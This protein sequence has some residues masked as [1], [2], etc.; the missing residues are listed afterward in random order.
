MLRGR[1][2]GSV[3]TRILSPVF[4]LLTLTNVMLL[5]NEWIA[6][7]VEMSTEVALLAIAVQARPI[8]G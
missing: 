3:G 5:T 7:E 1:I 6:L 8:A 2:P 4:V